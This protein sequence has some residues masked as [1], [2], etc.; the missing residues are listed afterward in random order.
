MGCDRRARAFVGRCALRTQYDWYVRSFCFPF[1][2]NTHQRTQVDD[3]CKYPAARVPRGK[4]S[5]LISLFFSAGS[6]GTYLA[7]QS[8]H[9]NNASFY[10][11]PPSIFPFSSCL[12]K[13]HVFSQF[14]ALVGHFLHH[15]RACCRASTVL[16]YRK[17]STAQHSAVSPHKAAKKVRADQSA[18]TQAS[19]QRASAYYCS[20]VP[21][22]QRGTA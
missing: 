5:Y 14:F 17:H 4:N 20:A 18:T 6:V 9:L 1:F 11:L 21:Q 16:Q 13:T 2:I 12:E 19:R 15:V 8:S 7:S 22:A 3:S 10:Y